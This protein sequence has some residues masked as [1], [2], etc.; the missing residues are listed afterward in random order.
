M[1]PLATSTKVDANIGRSDLSLK[2]VSRPAPSVYHPSV[3]LPFGDLPAARSKRSSARN[4]GVGSELAAALADVVLDGND[5]SYRFWGW[6]C[7]AGGQFYPRG[8]SDPGVVEPDRYVVFNPD[9]QPPFTGGLGDYNDASLPLSE[10]PGTPI[11]IFFPTVIYNEKV[12]IPVKL[13]AG[14]LVHTNLTGAPYLVSVTGAKVV[15]RDKSGD[16]V[17]EINA[18]KSSR[19]QITLSRSN[20]LPVV[21]G[22]LVTR[23]ALALLVLL[24]AACLIRR[25]Q[26]RPTGP[27]G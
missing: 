1:Y 26:A 24:L 3:L 19:Q 15:G 22:R 10:P 16:M 14:V 4:L 7:A 12:T 17:L 11:G 25:L 9:H 18:A 21:L 20:R 2:S 5:R 6:C 27:G 23:F 13:P 8:D